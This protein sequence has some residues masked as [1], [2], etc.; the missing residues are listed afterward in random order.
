M[1]SSSIWPCRGST[2]LCAGMGAAA[3]EYAITTE[4]I[5]ER[6]TGQCM[7]IAAGSQGQVYRCMPAGRGP[8]PLPQG[9]P[10]LGRMSTRPPIPPSHPP[11]QCHDEGA[12]AGAGA[13]HDAHLLA[14]LNLCTPHTH[15]QA[16]SHVGVQ[17]C[18]AD[19]LERLWAPCL[20]AFRS[21]RPAPADP[22]LS[23]VPIPF[24]YP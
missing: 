20:G 17:L 2:S 22:I 5:L 4:S 24:P 8:G 13:A 11:E 6:Q 14:I 7:A 12:L 1:P 3:R 9:T 23:S 15:I 10:A 19:S 16:C 21:P 18:K